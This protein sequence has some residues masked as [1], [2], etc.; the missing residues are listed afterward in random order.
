MK[1][2]Y[3]VSIT[4]HSA[5]HINGGTNADGVRVMV[6]TDGK[7]YIP[8]TLFKGMVREN[9]D[10]LISLMAADEVLQPQLTA[11]CSNKK[12]SAAPCNCPTCTMFGKAGFQ[13]SRVY[14]DN[15][16]TEQ[17]LCYSL[18]TNVAL[19]RY[20][21]AAKESALVTTQI[22]EPKDKAQKP[23][24]FS[25][26]VTVWLPTDCHAA[27]PLCIRSA[28]EMIRVIGHGKSRGLGFVEVNVRE[29]EGYI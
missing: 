19:D 29:A 9:F 23:V 25:G 13:R 27:I 8:A 11:A 16:E 6:Q 24:V 3:D 26:Q 2:V 21:C 20:L 7:A 10:K 1:I 28:M 22:V 18:R 12:N 4:L 14:V 5:M 17:E 15:M